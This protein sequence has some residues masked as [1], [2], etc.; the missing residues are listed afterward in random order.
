MI[1]VQDDYFALFFVHSV[2]HAIGASSGRPD[3]A[4]LPT[5]RLAD[6]TW[7]RDQGRRQEVDYCR[8]D[9]FRKLVGQYPSRRRCEDEFVVVPFNHR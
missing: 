1:Y 7:L 9:C 5:Q 2:E 3:T 8:C 6:P 4:E